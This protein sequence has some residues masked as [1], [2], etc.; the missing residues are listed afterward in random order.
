[1]NEETIEKFRDLLKDEISE[2]ESKRSILDKKVIK[3]TANF[4]VNDIQKLD[5][6]SND[7]SNINHTI[8]HLYS[9]I[10]SSL[11]KRLGI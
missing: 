2:L 1:M 9:I 8:F 3:L 4:N 5:K 11:G 7:I 10:G 6:L